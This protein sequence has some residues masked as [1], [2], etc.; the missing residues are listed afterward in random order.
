[1]SSQLRT[2]K[3]IDLC[4]PSI[5]YDAQ[6]KAACESI[7]A[8]CYEIIDDMNGDSVIEGVGDQVSLPKQGIVMIPNIMDIYD[9]A[10]ID[11]LAWQF[12]VDFYDATKDLEFRKNLVQ[13]AI[14]WHMT[15]GTIALVQWVLDTYWPGGASI[16]EWYE[17][18]SP[19]PPVKP[20]TNPPYSTLQSPPIVPP[21]GPSWHD[22]YRFRVLIDNRIIVPADEAQVLKLIEHYKPISRWCEGI[23]HATVASDC[24]IVWA[25]AMLRFEVIISEAPDNEM[26]AEEYHLIPPTTAS[27]PVASH[28]D[29]FTVSLPTL[30]TVDAV[31]TVTPSDGAGGTFIPAS[32][33]L[34]NNNPVAYFTYLPASAGAKTVTV[35]NDGGLTDPPPVAYTAKVVA[36]NYTLVGPASGYTGVA[37]STFTVALPAGTIAPDGVTITPNDGGAGGSFT[38]ASVF[39]SATLRERLSKD[40]KMASATFTYTPAPYA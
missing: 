36:V 23:F 37:S 19:L 24:N 29:L 18:Y 6:V 38:P 8:Q 28:S 2:S 15:K 3:L 10:L 21:V 5:N 16:M 7:D 33:K 34:S 12:H 22:R 32:A 9:E 39:L 40:A 13:M 25:G 11:I 20:P 1:M 35:S 30:S 27:G 31:V 14:Q 4:T 26:R 17:Y